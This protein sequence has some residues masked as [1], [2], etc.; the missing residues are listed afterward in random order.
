MKISIDINTL[1]PSTRNTIR[2]ELAGVLV[3]RFAPF[4]RHLQVPVPEGFEFVRLDRLNADVDLIL[5]FSDRREADP[6]LP[7]LNVSDLRVRKTHKFR[8]G[9]AEEDQWELVGK[10]T[11]LASQKDREDEDGWADTLLVRVEAKVVDHETVTT[12][13]EDTFSGSGCTHEHDCCGC[14]LDR[15]TEV[16]HLLDN[17]WVIKIAHSRNI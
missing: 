10:V 8:A 4:S 1:S 15:V 11:V 17:L 5:P 12:A 2:E 3:H 9:W 7:A 14:V 6:W 13:L 16:R